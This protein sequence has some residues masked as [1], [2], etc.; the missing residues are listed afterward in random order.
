MGWTCS[1]HAAEHTQVPWPSTPVGCIPAST[2]VHGSRAL[3]SVLTTLCGARSTCSAVG[4]QA[5]YLGVGIT[6]HH[7]ASLGVADTTRAPRVSWTRATCCS[8]IVLRAS[9]AGCKEGGFWS[10]PVYQQSKIVLDINPSMGF[11]AGGEELLLKD[12]R[13][14]RSTAK[15]LLPHTV[16]F[17]F[18]LKP[19]LHFEHFH[20]LHV[21][22][23]HQSWHHGTLG[24]V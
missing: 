13:T 16:L 18:K 1:C 21:E 20:T 7:R 11:R 12:R 2:T 6:G 9:G 4:C 10:Q 19:L 14:V 23:S 5:N 15:Y 8:S 24:R 3:Q 17:W 22:R